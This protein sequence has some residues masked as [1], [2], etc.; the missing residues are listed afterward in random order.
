MTTLSADALRHGDERL[1]LH[2]RLSDLLIK[3][4]GQG[5][6]TP[7]KAL[8]PE[9]E[10]ARRCDVA[11]GTVRKAMDNLTTQGIV[12]RRQG[13][14][15]FVRRLDVSH[16]L[17]RFFR[18]GDAPTQVPRGRVLSRHLAPAD[19]ST[20]EALRL[21]GGARVL[22][23]ERLRFLHDRPV[24]RENLWLPLPL[25]ESFVDVAPPAFPDLLYPYYEDA[26][27]VVITRATEDLSVVDADSR[28]IELLGCR[29]SDPVVAIER[30]ARS[31][32]GSPVERRISRGPA[33]T[34]RYR[35]EIS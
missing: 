12:E 27:G 8:P 6:F 21:P 17:L 16:S 9:N 14:G 15:T 34:F 11:V 19:P 4:I 24:L 25:F 7:T 29:E 3:A 32:D 28:D 5:E 26:V 23:L 2:Q 1:P 22:H 30:L 31:V 20:S 35:V 18:F 10:I 13:R 33:R